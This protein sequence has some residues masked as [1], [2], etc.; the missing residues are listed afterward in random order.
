[1]TAALPVLVTGAAGFVGKHVVLDLLRAGHAVRASVRDPVMAD[2]VRRAVLP[3]LGD[4]A[5]ERLNFATLDLTRDE[6]W[7]VAMAGCSALLHTA[8]PFPIAQ[9]KDPDEVIRPAV[10]GTRRARGCGRPTGAGS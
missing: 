1:M 10:D 5:G 6:G 7:A 9:P 3:H 2:Q 4:S 8:S